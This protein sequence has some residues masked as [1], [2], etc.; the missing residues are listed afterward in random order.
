M[1]ILK[2]LKEEDGHL[3]LLLN[4]EQFYG[5]LLNSHIMVFS[6]LF[7][8]MGLAFDCYHLPEHGPTTQVKSLVTS[9]DVAGFENFWET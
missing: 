9:V 3:C 8:F 4:I 6:V 1:A 5:V 7:F 2:V